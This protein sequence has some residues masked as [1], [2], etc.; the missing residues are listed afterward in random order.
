MMLRSYLVFIGSEM[1]VQIDFGVV[2]MAKYQD[3][4][5]VQ[6]YQS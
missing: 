3:C 5:L 1:K 6:N 4:T 2:E